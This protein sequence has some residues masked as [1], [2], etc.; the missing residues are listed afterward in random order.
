LALRVG[1]APIDLKLVTA[2]LLLLALVL[3]RLR[4]K[5]A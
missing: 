4:P 3:P 5:A 1:L 2:A